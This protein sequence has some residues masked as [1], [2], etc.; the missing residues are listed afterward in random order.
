MA[1]RTGLQAARKALRRF[2]E[3]DLPIDWDALDGAKYRDETEAVA[4]LL[5]KIPLNAAERA[6]VRA[7]AQALVRA[8]R[9][10]AKRQGVV[11][12][13]LQEFSLGTRE[14][15]AL[16]CLAEA[17][18]RIPDIAN[19]DRLIRDKL[20]GADWRAH[21]GA[22]P[23]LFVNAAS[24]GL[25]ITGKLVATSSEQGLSAAIGRL[26][27]RGGEPLIRAGL[28]LAMRLLGRQFVLGQTIAEALDHARPNQAKG[29]LYSYD[30][31]G[32]A[33]MTAA[34]AT[35]YAANTATP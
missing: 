26:L 4:A 17:L 25:V 31:L 12:T 19:R 14:G 13:F 21:I 20:G 15:L 10:S 9:D 32:E 7:E 30:M 29:Y 34:D 3:P 28:D 35:R 18:L 5:A 8:A 24:W 2:K 1:D 27:T 33:A 16:M 23:S 22:S 6:A 11:E